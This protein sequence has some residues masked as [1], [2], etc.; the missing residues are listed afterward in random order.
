M[1]LVSLVVIVNSFPYVV[2]CTAEQL[3]AAGAPEAACL[4]HAWCNRVETPSDMDVDRLAWNRR[5]LDG[6]GL[7]EQRVRAVTTTATGRHGIEGVVRKTPTALLT[8]ESTMVVDSR[9][10]LLGSPQHKRLS[11]PAPKAASVRG[12]A[13]AT[14]PACLPHA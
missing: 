2:S 11:A 4:P 10:G 14:P 9:R 12:A 13:D 1:N 7:S 3:L 6:V 8:R 5:K